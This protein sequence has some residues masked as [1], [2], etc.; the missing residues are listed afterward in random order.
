MNRLAIVAAT[1]VLALMLTACGE[2]NSK[3]TE[4]KTETTVV[5]PEAKPADQGT[6]DSTTTTTT[7]TTPDEQKTTTTEEKSN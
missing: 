1:G 7:T 2:D 5:Q 6:T 4:V 3:P